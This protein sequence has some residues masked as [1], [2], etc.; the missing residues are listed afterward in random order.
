MPPV[1]VS[2]GL[3]DRFV[4]DLL[5]DGEVAGLLLLGLLSDLLLL[6]RVAGLLLAVEVI[7]AL[8]GSV[9]PLDVP[10][11]GPGGR[12]E[13]EY[14]GGEGEL[15]LPPLPLLAGRGLGG[16]AVGFGPPQP[17]LD[18]GSVCGDGSRHGPPHSRARPAV[19]PSRRAH[20]GPSNGRRRRR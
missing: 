10:P 9:L 4:G 17:A 19:R 18:A 14:G 8:A 5:D 6:G 13:G 20:R 12:H 3:F 11:A 1:R 15:N 2:V 7:G 16:G